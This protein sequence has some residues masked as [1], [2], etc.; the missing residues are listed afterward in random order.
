MSRFVR[1]GRSGMPARTD[2]PARRGDPGGGRVGRR[3]G[4]HPGDTPTGVPGDAPRGAS[5]DTPI[6]KST[7]I[8]S[9]RLIKNIPVVIRYHP[10]WTG[11]RHR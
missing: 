9:Y 4:E 3:G 10:G 2:V 5:A 8:R 11:G 7:D 1:E 6:D